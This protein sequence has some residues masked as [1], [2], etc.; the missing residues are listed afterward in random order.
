MHTAACRQGKIV[1]LS[2]RHTRVHDMRYLAWSSD[3]LDSAN[4][5]TNAA[6]LQAVLIKS[7]ESSADD[8]QMCFTKN[9]W[10]IVP[11][12]PCAGVLFIP[13]PGGTSGASSVCMCA[14]GCKCALTGVPTLSTAAPRHRVHARILHRHRG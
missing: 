5:T 8:T 12:R 3:L 14:R 4:T 9:H 7:K 11:D 1:E 10:M 6:A 2:R 13:A